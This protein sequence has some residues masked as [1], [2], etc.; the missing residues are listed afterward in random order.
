[1]GYDWANNYISNLLNPQAV[2]GMIN[3]ARPWAV[4]GVLFLSASFGLFFIGF[5]DKIKVKSAANVIKYGG[6][7]AALCA[8]L[9]V[10]PSL[11]DIMVTL[12]GTCTLLVFFY[13]T[14]F[15]F[16]TKFH[17]LKIYSVLSLIFFYAATYMYSTRSYIEYLPIMQ[18]TIHLVQ[19]VWVLILEYYTTEKDFQHITK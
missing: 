14:V 1:M 17:F 18:K 19:I 2:N 12:S 10:F 5:S 9:T 4:G 16:K 15:L 6:L 3:T 13:I 11:H 7:M 8:F